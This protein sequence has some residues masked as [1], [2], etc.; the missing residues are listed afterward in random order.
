MD[1]STLTSFGLYQHF[2]KN[3]PKDDCII[4]DYFIDANDPV[5][6]RLEYCEENCRYKC[7][8]SKD[9]KRRK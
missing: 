1:K 6:V 9:Y 2:L 7:Y 4:N 5:K 8:V 3:L